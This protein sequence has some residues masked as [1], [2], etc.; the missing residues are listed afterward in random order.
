MDQCVRRKLSGARLS[1]RRARCKAFKEGL[2]NRSRTD[3]LASVLS[4]DIQQDSG[5]NTDQPIRS[6][7][8]SSTAIPTS[9]LPLALSAGDH[10]QML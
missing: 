7:S 6:L 8:L 10:T 3:A 2:V 5:E 9:E 1:K 4:A